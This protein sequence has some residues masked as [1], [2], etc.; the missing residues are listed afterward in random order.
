MN[1]TA[2]FFQCGWE[3]DPALL[4]AGRYWELPVGIDNAGQ[5]FERVS[6]GM[7][8]LGTF[9]NLSAVNLAMAQH[10]EQPLIGNDFKALVYARNAAKHQVL[11]LPTWD[12]LPQSE[13]C[14]RHRALYECSRLAAVLYANAVVFPTLED[15]PGIQEPLR[16]LRELLE[17]CDLSEWREG[18]SELLLWS[19]F[20]GG[21]GA[22]RSPHWPYFASALR[23]CTANMRELSSESVKAILRGF[24]WSDIACDEGATMLWNA[25]RF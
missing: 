9:M 18:V 20:I 14:G 4:V 24:V 16:Q 6:R 13:T 15:F 2:P 7:P 1:F 11:S 12:A 23:R 25:I 22:H 10:R 5:G 8:R 19:I 21:I 17:D 3:I